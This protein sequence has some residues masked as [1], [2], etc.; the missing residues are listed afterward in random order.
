LP[1]LLLDKLARSMR[2]VGA[3]AAGAGI[4]ASGFSRPDDPPRGEASVVRT[5]RC[6]RACARSSRVRTA[7]GEKRLAVGAHAGLVLALVR[8]FVVREIALCERR[9]ERELG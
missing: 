2:P 9:V 8:R 4:S 3:P 1:L 5:T 7:A 6:T